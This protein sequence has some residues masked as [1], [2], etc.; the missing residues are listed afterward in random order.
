ME[1][2]A[3]DNP[4]LTIAFALAAGTVALT[5]ARHLHIPGI[6]ILLVTHCF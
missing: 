1:P 6:V 5:M 3:F 4:A 2:R